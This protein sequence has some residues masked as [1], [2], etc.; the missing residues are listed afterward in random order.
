M[1]KLQKKIKRRKHMHS[2]FTSIAKANCIPPNNTDFDLSSFS[3]PDP[4]FDH[5]STDQQ[6]LA[7]TALANKD[8][9]TIIDITDL[10]NLQSLLFDNVQCFRNAGIY[11][12]A[13][14]WAMTGNCRSSPEQWQN[15]IA[16]CDI[17]KLRATGDALPT[18]PITVYRGIARYDDTDK[19]LK[20]DEFI[21]SNFWTRNK[22][23]ASWFAHWNCE[24]GNIPFSNALIYYTKVDPENILF[25]TQKT[26][27]DEVAVD[28][29]YLSNIKL[30]KKTPVPY[31]PNE[32]PSAYN[33]F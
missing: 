15:L 20:W 31:H 1:L 25:C 18:Q 21:F 22:H 29:E 6:S 2:T 23:I 3:S 11:E 13:L 12:E 10:H 28:I 32:P 7:N 17:D 14:Y 19:Y 24:R 26:L 30:L 33:R 9:K 27:E 5:I 8:A 16:W 4:T